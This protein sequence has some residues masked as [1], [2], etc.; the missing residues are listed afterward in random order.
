MNPYWKKAL[1]KFK[2]GYLE[3]SDGQCNLEVNE[4]ISK[5]HPVSMVEEVNPF[6]KKKKIL[7]Q[8]S[9]RVPSY[10]MT[11]DGVFIDTNKYDFLESVA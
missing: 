1:S 7:R 8:M 11:R 6:Y 5:I 2:S 3:L 9:K 4:L 10:T